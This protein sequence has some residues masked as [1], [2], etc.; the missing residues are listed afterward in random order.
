MEKQEHHITEV[1]K[2]EKPH[3]DAVIELCETR[4]KLCSGLKKKLAKDELWKLNNNISTAMSQIK[5]FVY[6]TFSILTFSS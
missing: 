4:T 2:E 6:K 3:E 5:S 1:F